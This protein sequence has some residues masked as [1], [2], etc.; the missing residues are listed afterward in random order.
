MG[1]MTHGREQEEKKRLGRQK[2]G[3]QRSGGFDGAVVSDSAGDGDFQYAGA[4]TLDEISS[5]SAQQEALE[6][7]RAD[8]QTQLES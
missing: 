7:K 2:K 3:G 8:L 1:S 4:V 6:E 5:L